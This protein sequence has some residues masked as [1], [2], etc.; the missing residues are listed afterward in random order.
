[1]NILYIHIRD[2]LTNFKMKLLQ[3]WKIFKVKHNINYL[4]TK[5]CRQI[6]MPQYENSKVYRFNTSTDLI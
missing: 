6:L 3:E 4:W 1:M 2:N 5:V